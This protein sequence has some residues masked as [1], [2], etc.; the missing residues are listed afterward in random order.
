M[1]RRYIWALEDVSRVQDGEHVH[2][3][4]ME[5]G[6]VVRSEVG[7]EVKNESVIK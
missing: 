7:R 3:M 1:V 5:V 2:V 4:R 6:L